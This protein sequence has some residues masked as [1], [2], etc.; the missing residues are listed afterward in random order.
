MVAVTLVSREGYL[1]QSINKQ[2]WQ[3][4]APDR[5]QPADWARPLDAKVA[6]PIGGRKVWV[7]GWLYI[8]QGHMNPFF[9]NY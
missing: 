4:E 2:G 9:F 3:Q 6:L 8:L 5:W 1:R 7:S